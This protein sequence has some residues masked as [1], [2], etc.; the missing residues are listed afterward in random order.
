MFGVA[1]LLFQLVLP[2]AHAL[3][4]NCSHAPSGAASRAAERLETAAPAVRAAGAPFAHPAV[5][6]PQTCEICRGL[7]QLR[8]GVAQT[9][10]QL[11]TFDAAP[12]AP[13]SHGHDVDLPTVRVADVDPRAPPA[14]S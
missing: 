12:T 11:V 2:L 10:L 6:D 3:E 13:L 5:H 7:Q 1:V 8:S 14:L 9:P 4:T